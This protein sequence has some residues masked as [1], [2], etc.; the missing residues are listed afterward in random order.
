MRDQDRAFP[1][2]IQ[3]FKSHLSVGCHSPP[4]NL[5]LPL[6]FMPHPIPLLIGDH[7]LEKNISN[8]L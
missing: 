6:S 4:K 8:N 7:I 3:K 2:H 1:T 5:V